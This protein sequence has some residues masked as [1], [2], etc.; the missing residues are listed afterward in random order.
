[1]LS[2]GLLLS[3]RLFGGVQLT[4]AYACEI[5]SCIC[6]SGLFAMLG[7]FLKL[8]CGCHGTWLLEH[9]A[10]EAGSNMLDRSVC[11]YLFMVA[12][13]ARLLV[14][15]FSQPLISLEREYRNAR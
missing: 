13:R 12:G 1:M 11:W 2:W 3:C 7:R 8:S 4:N 10:Y 14:L 6:T 9:G 5:L 15:T